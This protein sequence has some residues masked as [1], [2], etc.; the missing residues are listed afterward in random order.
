MPIYVL[1]NE[2]GL[3]TDVTV[4]ENV[5]KKSSVQPSSSDSVYLGTYAVFQSEEYLR[6]VRQLEEQAIL[7]AG[8]VDELY[9]KGGAKMLR[10][11]LHPKWINLWMDWR[12]TIFPRHLMG[13]A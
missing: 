11:K 13:N 7:E 12:D 4:G 10:E 3:L 8:S 6:E 9:A 1:V 5:F 2:D